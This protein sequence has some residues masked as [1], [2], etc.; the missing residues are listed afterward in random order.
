L[1][2][3]FTY[4][5][6][7]LINGKTYVGVHSTDNINDDY[8]GSGKRLQI[9]IEKYG[10]DNF[11]SI[12]MEYF[13]NVEEAY[14]EERFLVNEK[15]ILNENNYNLALGGWGGDR[16]KIVNYKISKTVK[17]LIENGLFSD[18][19]YS[20]IH[21][22]NYKNNPDRK[23]KLNKSLKKYYSENDRYNKGISPSSETK[24][25]L[26]NKTKLFWEEYNS[27]INT[28]I[29]QFSE[30]GIFIKEW[31]NI[32]IASKELKLNQRSIYSILMDNENIIWKYK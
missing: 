18:V 5:T 8:L 2:Y 1:T 6:K 3:N 32:R 17:S 23:K 10:R 31:D 13:D 26:S 20:K 24:K 15:W 28:P 16:G 12:P 14:E 9:A 11:I 27:K 21:K 4:Q 7:N 30:N 19:D 22:E 29:L 25:K